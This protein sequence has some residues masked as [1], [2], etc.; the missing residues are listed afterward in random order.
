MNQAAIGAALLLAGAVWF[1]AGTLS[2][3]QGEQQSA[4]AGAE[5]A[6]AQPDNRRVVRSTQPEISPGSAASIHASVPE[7]NSVLHTHIQR[8]KEALS[9][10]KGFEAWGRAQWT[11][12]PLG[13]GTH[14]WIVILSAG[15]SEVGYMIIQA[16]QDG[17]Y[18]LAEYGTGDHPLFSTGT[19]YRSLVQHELIDT[20]MT[21]HTWLSLAAHDLTR[22][23][24]DG[25]HAVWEIDNTDAGNSILIDAATG[26]IRTFNDYNP[27]VNH[28]LSGAAL[29]SVPESA[30]MLPAFD[31]YSSLNWLQNDSLPVRS[32]R[33]LQLFLNAEPLT[34]VSESFSGR[35]TV[36]LPVTGVAIWTG[37]TAY[38]ALGQ[39]GTRYLAF[40]DIVSLGRFFH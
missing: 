38:V 39:E 36:P 9:S 37:D 8:W 6:H 11:S 28:K 15:G 29:S 24:T 12:A 18:K 27:A 1:T 13:P 20:S 10:Q 2:F 19:L 17:S 14:G 21:Y 40:E 7:S 22:L 31:P 5:P 4:L 26:E 25:L 16:A 33:D 30:S 3:S 34:F 32:I 35:L 23:Y